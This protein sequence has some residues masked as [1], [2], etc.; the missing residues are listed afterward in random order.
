MPGL[1]LM[2][3]LVS[4]TGLYGSVISGA[5]DCCTKH[6][7]GNLVDA[8]LKACIACIAEGLFLCHTRG[9]LSYKKSSTSES[10]DDV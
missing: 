3:G 10:E 8:K 9:E 6:L 2:F 4:E 5:I 1:A 7:K